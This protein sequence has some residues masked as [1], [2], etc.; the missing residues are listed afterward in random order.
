MK[1][2]EFEHHSK[3]IIDHCWELLFSKAD[4]YADGG[5]RLFNFKAPMSLFRTNPAK[6][7]MM[8]DSK[9]I[10]SM[11][12]IAEDVDKGILPTRELLE[13]K[14]GDY[15]NYGLLFYANMLE[16]MDEK[17][18]LAIDNHSSMVVKDIDGDEH[19]L[20]FDE[21]KEILDEAK[22]IL[23]EQSSRDSA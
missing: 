11:V 1:A 23:D 13:E 10:A 5:D 3:E 2:Q 12:K 16:I 18:D 17:I 21:V 7:C 22:E 9:H 19:H 14:V 15:I 4:E 8:Y 6:V 20:K